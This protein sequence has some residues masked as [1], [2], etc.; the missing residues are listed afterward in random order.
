MDRNKVSCIGAMLTQPGDSTP[1]LRYLRKKTTLGV[2]SIENIAK[3]INAVTVEDLKK[4]YVILKEKLAKA[5]AASRKRK[6]GGNNAKTTASATTSGASSSGGNSDEP[7]I[8][9]VPLPN[10][11]QTKVSVLDVWAAVSETKIRE[12]HQRPVETLTLDSSAER[13]NAGAN[14]PPDVIP[15]MQEWLSL[16]TQLNAMS[17]D[18]AAHAKVQQQI[19]EAKQTSVAQYLQQN[20]PLDKCQEVMLDHRGESRAYVLRQKESTK[21]KPVR[22]TVFRPYIRQSLEKVIPS[23][24]LDVQSLESTLRIKQDLIRLLTVHFNTVLNQQKDTKTYVALDRVP[25]RGAA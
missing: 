22:I 23:H 9:L 20:R 24:A 8:S 15:L 14:A 11:S 3:A 18:K 19:I 6:R 4:H 2:L 12:A 10:V 5:S 1:T 16:S 21:Q 13:G 25:V 17:R 7:G